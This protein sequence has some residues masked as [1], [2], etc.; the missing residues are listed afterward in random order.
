[1][2]KKSIKKRPAKKK[3]AKKKSPKNNLA[4]PIN[5]EANI[6]RA[7]EYLKSQYDFRRNIVSGKT[8]YK[9]KRATNYKEMSDADYNSIWSDAVDRVTQFTLQQLKQI[10]N[11]DFSQEYNPF[12]DYFDSLPEWDG[13]TDYIS[14]IASEVK[15]DNDMLFMKYFKKWLVGAVA[16]CLDEDIKNEL[17]LILTGGQGIGKTTWLEGLLPDQLKEYYFA[18]NVMP[19]NKDSLVL[20]SECL[21]INVDEFDTLGNRK[22][23]MLKE[24]V[25]K[26]IVKLRK[27]FRADNESFTRRASFVGSSNKREFLTDV[28]GNRRFLCFEAEK[29]IRGRKKGL[30]DLAYSQALALFK[31]GFTYYTTD[32]DIAELEE[33]NC[34]YQVVTLEEELIEKYFSFADNHDKSTNVKRMTATQI[35]EFINFRGGNASLK[36]VGEAM[37]KL[38]FHRTTYQNKKVYVVRVR[39]VF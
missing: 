5:K 14:M 37:R 34:K 13:K 23:E 6:V 8:A 15:T 32:S 38:K 20:L 28:E 29:I 35:V 1:M 16:C 21:I 7:K 33:H 31:G 22:L 26:P 10:S 27:A 24:L 2:K 30:L 17:V 11:S 3:P 4:F 12:K 19:Q 18:G 9:K 36:A 39:T 25:S